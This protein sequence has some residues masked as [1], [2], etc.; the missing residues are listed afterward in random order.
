MSDLDPRLE[1]MVRELATAQETMVAEEPES[2]VAEND[3]FRDALLAA[4]MADVALGDCCWV[5]GIGW[6]HW[7]GVVWARVPDETVVEVIRQHV[8]SEFARAKLAEQQALADAG[9]EQDADQAAAKQ[10]EAKRHKALAAAWGRYTSRARLDALA[11]LARGIL[12]VP[13]EKFDASPDILNVRNGIVDLRTGELQPHQQEQYCTRVADAEYRPGSTHPDW[14]AA[15]EA[16]PEDVRGWYQRR[17]G[18]AVTGHRV[19]D[20]VLMVQQGGGANGKTTVVGGISRA[21]GDYYTS[22]SHRAL[23]ADPSQHPTELMAFRGA[24]LAVVEETPE[25]RRLSIIRL[26]EVVGQPTVARHAR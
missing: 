1:E 19:P 4:V 14:D 10:V 24:R 3:R 9:V 21:L 13:S 16:V 17:M 7:D 8:A 5:P 11:A 12:L 6:R 2:V 23:L 15:L 26:K 22:V 20:D 25:E 18:Q